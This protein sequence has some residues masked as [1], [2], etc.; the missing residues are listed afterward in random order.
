MSKKPSLTNR[1]RLKQL[2][3]HYNL[4]RE[5]IFTHDK[6]GYV[7]LTRT[8]VEKI[9]AHDNIQVSYQKEYCTNEGACYMATAI[10]GDVKI[11]TLG[12]AHKG[13]CKIAY[14]P[15]MAEKR[16]KARAVLMLAGFYEIGCY[17]EVE[18]DE[19]HRNKSNTKPQESGLAEEVAKLN[20][21]TGLADTMREYAEQGIGG[22]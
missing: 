6:F 21:G 17:S 14:Y 9:M 2:Y 12:S 4:N 3:I 11:E 16:A 18:A 1:E 22:Q 7:M 10:R 13:N 20:S 15:E 19:F 5:D 8:G